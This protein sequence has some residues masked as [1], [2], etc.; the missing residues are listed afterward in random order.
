M[1]DADNVS[2]RDSRRLPDQGAQIGRAEK[3]HDEKLGSLMFF[4][5]VDGDDI[6]VL[7]PGHRAG[8]P[9]KPFRERG[10]AAQVGMDLLDGDDTVQRAVT[11]FVDDTH[12]AAGDFIE[13]LIFPGKDVG[14]HESTMVRFCKQKVG[15][16]YTQV[17]GPRPCQDVR[18]L[19][20]E[21]Q[22]SIPGVGLALTTAPAKILV[23]YLCVISTNGR[24][25]FYLLAFQIA[26]SV[27]NGKGL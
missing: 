9:E 4:N 1:S 10:V 3:L 23:A 15:P 20:H 13:D 21:L 8:F 19:L 26:H 27:R 5:G 12:P 6:V 18:S 16:D 2:E 22:R 17:E 25:L 24:N 7:Q 14:C 11:G